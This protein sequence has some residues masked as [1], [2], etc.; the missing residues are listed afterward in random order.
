MARRKELPRI[1]VFMGAGASRAFEFPL[2]SDLLP[3]I[4]SRLEDGSLFK[5]Y[6]NSKRHRA[7][8]HRFLRDLLPGFGK[9][10]PEHLPLITE[11]LSLVDHSITTGLALVPESPRSTHPSL[12]RLIERAIYEAL[13]WEVD[14]DEEPKALTSLTAWLRKQIESPALDLAFLTT[15][16]DP[17]VEIRL[18]ERLGDGAEYSCDFGFAWRDVDSG[19]IVPRPIDASLRFYRLHGALNWLR[20]PLCDHIYV[21]PDGSIAPQGF[22]EEHDTDE[23]NS[24]HCGYGPLEP[25]M[26]AP[27]SVR[28]IRDTNL[29]E[30]WRHATEFLRTASTWIIIGYSLPQ[31]DVAI[32]SMFLRAQAAWGEEWGGSPKIVVV[33]HGRSVATEA[34]YRAMFAR[35]RYSPEG[36][37]G[38]AEALPDL[39]GFCERSI[40]I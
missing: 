24:C 28:D 17:T 31:E 8:L 29:L 19:R 21:N 35:C 22:R 39:E 30:I 36:M 12:R 5:G 6:D 1:A 14:Y 26:V 7:T 32:R 18:F 40:R 34:R 9:A 27:S 16:Y 38:F 23:G 2:T 15:N 37:D 33:Q 3:T 20:C 4:R 11:V 25:V 13:D 10:H